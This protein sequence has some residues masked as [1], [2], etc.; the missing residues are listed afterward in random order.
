MS[1]A[2]RVFIRSAEVGLATHNPNFGRQS[3]E[4]ILDSIASELNESIESVLSFL[5]AD[6]K[7]MHR[8]TRV[9][10][11]Q[12][13]T[14]RI[15]SIQ[16][17]S[18]PVSFTVCEKH[19]SCLHKPSSKWLEMLFR[20]IKFYRLLFRV[21]KYEDRVELLIDGPQSLLS[22]S[23]RYGLQF[24]MF[25]TSITIIQRRMATGCYIIVG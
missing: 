18:M 1:F 7:D 22:Q 17:G 16:S 11:S 21:W 8:L 3:K 9:S 23:N 13:S 25:L 2:R 10:T 12:N 14:G 19:Q 6:H 4:M 24:A 5:Y 20:R 15:A